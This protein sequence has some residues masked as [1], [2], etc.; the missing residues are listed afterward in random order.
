VLDRNPG[1]DPGT[2]S[3]LVSDSVAKKSGAVYVGL[4]QS[5]VGNSSSTNGRDCLALLLS[6]KSNFGSD[7]KPF[8]FYNFDPNT[9]ELL[10]KKWC[11]VSRNGSPTTD[12][13]PPYATSIEGGGC[14]VLSPDGTEVML[15]HEYGRWGRCGGAVDPGESSLE[16]ALR[17]VVEETAVELNLESDRAPVRIGLCYHQPRSR[18]GRVNDNFLLFIVYAKSKALK[19]DEK[20]ISGARWFSVEKLVGEWRRQVDGTGS[21]FNAKRCAALGP[22]CEKVGFAEKVFCVPNKVE[23]KLINGPTYSEEEA[24]TVVIGGMELH[25]LDKLQRGECRPLTFF[26]NG[27]HC[28]AIIS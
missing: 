25:C 5:F 1:I 28:P 8:Q 12:M 10:Y 7:G 26:D 9:N 4:P 15:V 20:E 21:V 16:T 11:R 24:E 6:D 19:I 13:V 23:V 27:K 2:L 22:N 18:D 3:T 17:E 14:L